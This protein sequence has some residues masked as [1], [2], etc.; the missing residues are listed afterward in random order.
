MKIN[1]VEALAGITKKNIR[2]YEEQGLLCPR[3]NAENGYRN[4]SQED[5]AVLQRIRLLRKLGMPIEE[6]RTLF[7]GEKTLGQGMREHLIRLEREKRSMEQSIALCRELTTAEITADN[8]E[9]EVLLSRMAEMER[10]GAAFREPE[11]DIRNPYMAPII[12]TI[13]MVLVSAALCAVFI[14]AYLAEPEDAPPLW[15]LGL[16][17]AMFAALGVGAVMALVQRI[18]E[19]RKGELNDAKFY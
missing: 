3:R 15:F 1:E 19:I 17:E 8:W 5:V 16:L 7:S 6:I 2:F 10:S 11:G 13:V 14:F 4:Y 12:V 9:P 18:R